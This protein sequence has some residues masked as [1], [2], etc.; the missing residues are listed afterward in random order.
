MATE[1]MKEPVVEV[2]GRCAPL[3]LRWEPTTAMRFV[4]SLGVVARPKGIARN[5][6]TWPLKAKRRY[7]L[8][9]GVLVHERTRLTGPMKRPNGLAGKS[10]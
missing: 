9:W 7:F 10:S 4:K 5:W 3:S 6:K 2:L 1:L 8:Y